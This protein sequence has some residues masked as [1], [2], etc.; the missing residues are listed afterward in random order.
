MRHI[1]LEPI[2]P[3]AFLVAGVHLALGAGLWWCL[4]HAEPVLQASPGHRLAWV[5]PADFTSANATA[6]PQASPATDTV[7]KSVPPAQPAVEPPAPATPKAPSIDIVPK[8]IALNSAQVAALI[9][10]G[11]AEPAPAAPPSSTQ[12]APPADA[13]PRATTERLSLEQKMDRLLDAATK[14]AVGTGASG[15]EKGIRLDDVD[16]AIIRAFMREWVP[17]DDSKLSPNQRTAHLDMSVDR[18]GRVLS[19]ELTHPS[20]NSAL[21]MSV[22]EAVGRLGKIEVQL[23][24]SYPKDRYEF[25]VNLHAE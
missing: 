10:Q 5:S 11:P 21:D 16:R 15:A 18:N 19:F 1:H 2:G 22:L 6:I 7:L 13:L 9:G 20:G 24:P 14:E 4:R 3:F 8:A 23:P 17:P 25:Q 12:T